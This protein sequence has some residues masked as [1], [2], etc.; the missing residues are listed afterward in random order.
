[1][2]SEL[3][4]VNIST[5]SGCFATL[6]VASAA[7]FFEQVWN[8]GHGAYAHVASEKPQERSR[9][10]MLALAEEVID[11]SKQVVSNRNDG[12]FC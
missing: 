2:S 8:F 5:A 10:K 6:S 4:S 1:M 12:F 9:G 3:A 11:Q 7:S